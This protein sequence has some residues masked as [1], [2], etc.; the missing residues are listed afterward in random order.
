MKLVLVLFSTALLASC[1]S[2]PYE[3]TKAEVLDAYRQGFDAGLALAPCSPP[4]ITKVDRLG[5]AWKNTD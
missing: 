2:N 3:F 1:A 4:D 5:A